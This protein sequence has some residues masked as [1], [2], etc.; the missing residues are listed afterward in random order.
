MGALP[1][2]VHVYVALGHRLPGH[3]RGDGGVCPY[4]DLTLRVDACGAESEVS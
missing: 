4:V 1:V 2:V 3:S